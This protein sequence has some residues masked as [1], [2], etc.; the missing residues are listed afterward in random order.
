M[1]RSVLGYSRCLMQIL[2]FAILFVV[3]ACEHETTPRLTPATNKTKTPAP[4]RNTP[5]GHSVVRSA[6]DPAA[7]AQRDG[8]SA[9]G[10]AVPDYVIQ[11]LDYIQDHG[12]SP[13][14]YVGGRVFENREKRLPVSDARGQRIRYREWD[15]H[16]QR[17]G[18][19]RGPE[20][21]VTGSNQKAYYT[22]D[23]YRT[24]KPLN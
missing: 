21:V 1:M 24:F 5:Q 13:E 23:H 18:R 20:R 7:R 6:Q 10:Q 11:T 8:R 9:P 12:R 3:S 17:R 4:E 14:G 2:L 16:P 15:V 19:N 22:R